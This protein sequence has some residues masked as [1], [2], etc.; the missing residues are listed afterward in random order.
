LGTLALLAVVAIASVVVPVGTGILLGTVLAFT[1]YHLYKPLARRTRKP[2]LV[3][4]GVTA[5]TTTTVVGTLG[6]LGYL[7]VLQGVAVFAS[8]P[9]SLAPGGPADRIVHRLAEPLRVFQ[10]SP[11]T[12]AERL[13][14]ALGSAASS[15]AGWATQLAG[16][17][18]DAG[19]AIFFMAITM[20]FVL[21]NWAFLSRRAERLMPLNP[22]HTR[23]LMRETRRLGQT[24]VIGNFG[25][26]VIQG[27]LGGAGYALAHVPNASLLGAITA[28]ASLVPV[29][30]TMLVW[31]P[32]GLILLGIGHVGA[33]VFVLVWGA[34]AVVGF[35]DYV[36]RPRLVGGGQATSTWL[37][38]VALFGGIK[39]FGVIG[40]LLGPILVGIG[41]EA[42]RLS[43]RARRFR[44]G[45]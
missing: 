24:V 44:L 33:G 40:V 18:S 10:L 6:V 34:V 22:R 29:F 11:A 1:T 35:C 41:V 42:L 38:F 9:K 39:L 23:R 14:G 2:A 7:L 30:G 28:V 13:S 32:A 20:F 17:L 16:T 3:A 37:T 36:L 12:V 43:E 26:G 15:L 5:V 31:V 19:L 4:F 25:T 45:S 8:L 21:T 27:I